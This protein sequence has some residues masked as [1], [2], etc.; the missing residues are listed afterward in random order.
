MS[1]WKGVAIKCNKRN[2]MKTLFLQ[3]ASADTKREKPQRKDF[4]LM[5]T[6]LPFNILAKTACTALA[7]AVLASATSTAH[8][9]SLI[10]LTS[11]SVI[12]GSGS[13]SNAA[14]NSGGYAAG[15]V[16]NN[17]T[18]TVSEAT[19]TGYWLGKEGD[20][21]EYFVVD[22]GSSVSLSSIQLFN[23]HNGP[24]ND[25]ATLGY[26]IFASNSVATVTSTETGQG[27]FNL[28]SAVSLGSGSLAFQSSA[29]DPIEA[30][31]FTPN[32]GTAYRY[33]RFNTLSFQAANGVTP[34]GVGLSEMRVF[35]ASAA[36]EPGSIALLL[37]A[38]VP[39]VGIVRRR[40]KP[41]TPQ[42]CQKN[43]L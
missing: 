38:G 37:T 28:S 14:Y 40:T 20:A 31:L 36:P 25:R 39:V 8:A 34:L 27:G 21:Q 5:R 2:R 33:L 10:S 24:V 29:N 16:F 13:W 19:Q 35:S 30:E 11:A 23:T 22:L 15:N 43:R 9:Q 6:F 41:S 1:A 7:V 26:Q 17:Q 3:K 18:G 32:T 4:I 12:G 42:K